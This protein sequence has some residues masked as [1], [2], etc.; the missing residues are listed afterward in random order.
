MPIP[1]ANPPATQMTVTSTASNSTAVSSARRHIERIPAAI[2]VACRAPFAVAANGPIATTD[3]I[4]QE[5][6]MIAS[7]ATDTVQIVDRDSPRDLNVMGS[8]MAAVPAKHQHPVGNVER[9]PVASNT[10]DAATVHHRMVPADMAHRQDPEVEAH[11]HRDL[12]SRGR[13]GTSEAVHLGIASM[14]TQQLLALV[15]AHPGQEV[16]CSN[17]RSQSQRL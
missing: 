17:S 4:R 15:V 10:V 2:S 16:G 7:V 13:A 8:R 11:T 1:P 5:P 6:M 9:N 3:R 12:G 14:P